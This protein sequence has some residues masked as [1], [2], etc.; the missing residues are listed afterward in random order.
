MRRGRITAPEGPITRARVA[1][2]RLH[3]FSQVELATLRIAGWSFP[4]PRRGRRQRHL[5]D[6]DDEYDR[7]NDDDDDDDQQQCTPHF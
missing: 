5:Q 1:P 7:H 2:D 6:T 3:E 4:F